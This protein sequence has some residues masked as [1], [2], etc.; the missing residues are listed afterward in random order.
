[1]YI[2][3][4]GLGRVQDW[5]ACKVGYVLQLAVPYYE[6]LTVRQNLFFVAHMR[7]P[8]GTSASDKCERVEQIIAEVSSI[9]ELYRNT[10]RNV[11]TLASKR[12]P[13]RLKH[14]NPVL[15][16]LGTRPV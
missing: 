15:S 11:I 9:L 5:Y 16:F 2:N 13:T 10:L 12:F 14:L 7:L 1:M 3:G 6:E 8:K 4:V